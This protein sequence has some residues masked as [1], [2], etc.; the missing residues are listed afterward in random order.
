MKK[1]TLV[2]AIVPR[3]DGEAIARAASGAGAP[4]GT[5]LR[6][7][8]TA[9]SALLQLLGLGDTAREVLL[10][11]VPDDTVSAVIEAVRA[12]SANRP[13]RR[14]ALFTH[15]VLD[16]A[17]SGEA[18]TPNEE[19][20][21]SDSATSQVITV[22]V[23]KGYAEDAMAAARKAGATGGTVLS[24]RGTAKPDDAAFFGVPLVPEKEVLI[25]HVEP[26]KADA[27]FAAVRELPCF[28]EKGSGV[29]FRVPVGEFVRLGR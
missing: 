27:V 16:F 25:I 13:S 18:P 11:V 28:Q 2:L 20:A 7:R 8:G 22:I 15:D 9:S 6:G 29:V 3:G 1:H 17:R 10:T 24:A 5:I 14:G 19:K 21:M 23:N 26:G 4:G 12:D